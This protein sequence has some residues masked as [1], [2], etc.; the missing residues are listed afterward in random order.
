MKFFLNNYQPHNQKSADVVAKNVF[1]GQL[2]R[3]FFRIFLVYFVYVVLLFLLLFFEKNYTDIL[4]II[5]IYSAA[6]IRLLPSFTK[7]IAGMQKIK[8]SKVVI[9]LIYNEFKKFKFNK[10]KKIFK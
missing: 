9:D 2:P 8:F 10:N 1:I 3:L 6:G 7:L 4:P 5:V